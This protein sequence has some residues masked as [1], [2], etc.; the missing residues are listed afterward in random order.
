MSLPHTFFMGRGGTKKLGYN[1]FVMSW[2]SGRGNGELTAYSPE[3]LIKNSNQGTSFLTTHTLMSNGN[4]QIYANSQTGIQVSTEKNQIYVSDN[5]HGNLITINSFNGTSMNT[6][7]QH[8]ASY[9][10]TG[11]YNSSS[12]FF[13]KTDFG[14]IRGSST[15]NMSIHFRAALGLGGWITDPTPI[16]SPL[17]VHKEDATFRAGKYLFCMGYDTTEVFD[18]SIS[19][20]RPSAQTHILSYGVFSADIG[21]VISP[22]DNMLGLIEANSTV[23]KFWDYDTGT[24]LTLN[25]GMANWNNSD[26]AGQYLFCYALNPSDSFSGTFSKSNYNI[27]SSGYGY[28]SKFSNFVQANNQWTNAPSGYNWRGGTYNANTQSMYLVGAG[29][30]SQGGGAPARAVSFDQHMAAGSVGTSFGTNI[31]LGNRGP[32]RGDMFSHKLDHQVFDQDYYN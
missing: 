27:V 7:F 19:P 8:D 26:N 6:S 18:L 2:V 15:A 25:H 10:Y 12:V 29:S 3:A 28:P 23:G 17:T 16:S 9:S 24:F 1:P 5:T 22:R 11:G 32:F 14:N 21:I 4:V 30:G 31:Y 20:Y 13:G